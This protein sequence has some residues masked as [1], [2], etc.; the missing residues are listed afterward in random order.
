MTRY[1]SPRQARRL[2]QASR[3]RSPTCSPVFAHTGYSGSCGSTLR[4]TR[5]WTSAL[6]APRHSP[7]SARAPV[8]TPGQGHERP[9]TSDPGTSRA[10]IAKC[11]NGSRGGIVTATETIILQPSRTSHRRP[12]SKART[13][14][15]VLTDV[16]V[17][18]VLITAGFHVNP[19]APRWRIANGDEASTSTR[20]HQL[21]HELW[22][23]GGSPYYETYFSVRPSHLPG[24]SRD[25]D[26]IGGLVLVRLMSLA[27]M[28]TATGLLYA[29]TRRLFGYWPAVVAIGLVRSRS[30]SRSRLARTGDV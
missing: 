7:R 28:L 1:S 3:R 6:T 19:T 13:V 11:F 8:P 29:T 15:R 5:A 22:H 26:H 14:P 4:I 9:A 16:P 25:A 10:T 24:A 12:V 20:G 21:I 2:P 27:F 30:A 17:A 18:A 23:G